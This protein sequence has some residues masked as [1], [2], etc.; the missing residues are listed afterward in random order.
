[1]RSSKRRDDK[2]LSSSTAEVAGD[3][4][5]LIAEEATAM[6]RMALCFVADASV[7][8]V[9]ERSKQAMLKRTTS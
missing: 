9:R 8:K 3:K 6:A 4:G 5:S 2:S 1:M 7:Q